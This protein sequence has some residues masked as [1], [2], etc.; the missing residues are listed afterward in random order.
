M[1]DTPRKSYILK[2]E[3]LN[4]LNVIMGRDFLVTPSAPF[5]SLTLRDK[6]FLRELE[7]Y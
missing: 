7:Q 6:N 1:K 3:I 5:V 2:L 4:V